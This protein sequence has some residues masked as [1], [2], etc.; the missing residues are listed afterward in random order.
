MQLF[1]VPVGGLSSRVC[2]VSSFIYIYKL[3]GGYF[4]G[5]CNMCMLL[6]SCSARHVSRISLGM[7]L[8]ANAGVPP[9]TTERMHF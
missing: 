3:L 2:F 4:S 6:L 5:V 7:Q 8:Y 1:T 9:T